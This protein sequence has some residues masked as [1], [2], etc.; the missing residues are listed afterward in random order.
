MHRET[1]ATTS[2]S[3]GSSMPANTRKFEGIGIF[4]AALNQYRVILVRF[5][6]G[7]TKALVPSIFK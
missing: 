5:I 1:N 2:P 3:H 6:V 4:V 7:G